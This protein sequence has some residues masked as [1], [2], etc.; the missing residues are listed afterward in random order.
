MMFQPNALEDTCT[1]GQKLL[2]QWSVNGEE[3]QCQYKSGNTIEVKIGIFVLGI[4]L[5]WPQ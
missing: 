3:F 4:P 1:D 5:F 2:T